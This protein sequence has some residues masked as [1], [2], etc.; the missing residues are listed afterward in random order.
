[1]YSIRVETVFSAAH[2]LV[3]SG[4]RETVH[5]HDWRVRA[6]LEG[7]A[8]DADGLLCDFHTVEQTLADIVAPLRNAD[9]NS[10][11]PFDRVN[12]SAERVAEHIARALASRLDEALA[13]HA[14]VAWVSVTEAPGCVATYRPGEGAV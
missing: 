6:E 4:E 7:P 13:P 14:R 10:T 3:I 8:L 5:G 2:A 11:P 12:P 9:L 1:M